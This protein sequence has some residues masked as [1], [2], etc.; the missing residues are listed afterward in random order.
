[1]TSPSLGELFEYQIWSKIKPVL[2]SACNTPLNNIKKEIIKIKIKAERYTTD[3]GNF[4]FEDIK[5]EFD[6]YKNKI[7]E[8]NEKNEMKKIVL[9]NK[10]KLNK[11]NEINFDLILF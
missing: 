11:N 1:M 2:A 4:T 6:Q 9:T 8:K 5:Q 7:K 10:T 3:E